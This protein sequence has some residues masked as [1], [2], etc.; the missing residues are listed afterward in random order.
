MG[1]NR[2]SG[3]IVDGEFYSKHT[4]ETYTHKEIT[5]K[6]SELKNKNDFDYFFKVWNEGNTEPLIKLVI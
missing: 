2:N 1:K 6:L 3:I 4:I 5:V